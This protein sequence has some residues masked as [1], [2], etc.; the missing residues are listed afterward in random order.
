MNIFIRY[1]YMFGQ[2]IFVE[3]VIVRSSY[4]YGWYCYQPQNDVLWNEIQNSQREFKMCTSQSSYSASSTYD[5]T[6]S[7]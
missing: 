6:L 7:R 4:T 2:V 5:Q 3:K 1:I